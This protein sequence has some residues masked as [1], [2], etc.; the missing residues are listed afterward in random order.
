MDCIVKIFGCSHSFHGPFSKDRQI[1]CI[2]DLINLL[3][4]KGYENILIR[5]IAWSGNSNDKIIDD[6]YREAELDSK[7]NQEFIYIIQ[8]SYLNRLWLPN[9]INMIF[10]SALLDEK[11]GEWP[12]NIPNEYKPY[13]KN[14][15]ESFLTCFYDD[16]LYFNE[17]IKKIDFLKSY[18]DSKKIKFIHFLWDTISSPEE[19]VKSRN[20]FHNVY[21]N[22][23]LKTGT[24]N[25]SQYIK[26][27]ELELIE[28]EENIFNF[29]RISF[30]KKITNWH[31]FGGGNY[32]LHL[33]ENGNQYLGKI[34]LNK[35]YEKIQ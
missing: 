33:T 16:E 13:L 21:I 26:L 4:Q 5:N 11:T 28:F 22:N 10:H 34:L 6:V 25:R 30:D 18:L 29:S 32:D 8:Y 20:E 12:P 1:S 9:K 24:T 35:L 3:K 2:D 14:M 15:Y 27:K 23:Q 31:T 19:M 17:L 7:Q